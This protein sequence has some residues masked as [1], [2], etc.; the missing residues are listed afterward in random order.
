MGL[1]ALKGGTMNEQMTLENMI[2]HEK[3]AEGKGRDYWDDT[4]QIFFTGSK[5]FGLTS[6]LATVCLGAE[7]E[8]LTFL[9]GGAL[10]REI[11]RAA[12]EVL[13]WIKEL[14]IKELLNGQADRTIPATERNYQSGAR[15]VSSKRSRLVLDS[16]R[17][18][19][20]ARRASGKKELSHRLP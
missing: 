6:D 20:G 3:P 4:G 17:R 8:V 10:P 2:Q 15:K 19:A 12:V 14:K 18:P 9:N 16:R 7:S 5:G 1:A 13:E 11:N